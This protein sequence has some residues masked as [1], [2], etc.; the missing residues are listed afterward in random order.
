M[1][2]PPRSFCVKAVTIAPGGERPYDAAEWC[3]AIV[4]VERGEVELEC[5]SGAR[6]RFGS[7]SLIWLCDMPL[8]ALHSTGAESVLLVAVSRSDEL[9]ARRVSL[10]LDTRSSRKEAHAM[11]GTFVWFD[12]H[13]EKLD[14]GDFYTKLLGWSSEPQ[15]DGHAML[16]AGNGPFAM[17]VAHGG[18]TAAW[19]PYVQVEDLNDA[20]MRAVGLGATVLQEPTEGPAGRYSWIRDTGGA[21]LALFEPSA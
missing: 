10:R 19:V 7:G 4:S 16:S 9:M 6:R 13:S 17:I 11:S 3:D 5:A 21:P 12:L 20:H 15:G 1:A 18:D 2:T 8:R 14:A